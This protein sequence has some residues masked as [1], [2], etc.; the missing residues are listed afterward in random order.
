[1]TLSSLPFES[2]SS[3]FRRYLTSRAGNYDYYTARDLW[4]D[5][6]SEL[7]YS[8]DGMM[9]FLRGNEALGVEAREVM[10]RTSEFNGGLDV[11]EN[12][13]LGPEGLNG[14]IGSANM[15]GLDLAEVARSNNAA[16]ES[17]LEADPD[18]LVE[19]WEGL[20]YVA[21]T[22][23]ATS[24][25]APAVI[26]SAELLPLAET[27][28]AGGSLAGD[29]GGALLEGL[30]PAM[31]AY[32]V[33]SYVSENCNDPDVDSTAA[34]WAAAGGTVLLYCN[35]ITGP[36]AWTCTGLYSAF[37]L[38]QVGAKVYSHLN[39]PS[40]PGQTVNVTAR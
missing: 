37:K 5:I 11:P 19:A 24:E 6:P 16:V 39:Q 27:A 12:L 13:V 36:I 9:S 21:S 2:L 22:A 35:P 20:S 25:V 10:H 38:A 14:T 8:E 7:R 18:V 23:A 33:G 32:K 34:G 26:E 17:I 31:A 28:E 15:T 3:E 40:V 30:V 1:M 29:I 4:S